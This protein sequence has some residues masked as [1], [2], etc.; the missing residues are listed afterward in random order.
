[1]FCLSYNILTI[2]LTVQNHC[3]GEGYTLVTRDDGQAVCYFYMDRD[4]ISTVINNGDNDF[5]YVQSK[6]MCENKV[7]LLNIVSIN[8]DR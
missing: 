8:Y 2:T 5:N 4:Y 7:K 6:Q 1:M 3:Q